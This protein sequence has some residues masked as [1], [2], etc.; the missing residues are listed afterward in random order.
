[1]V[2]AGAEKSPAGTRKRAMSGRRRW[3][4]WLL[5]VLALS[6]C[7]T[8]PLLYKRGPT[9]VYWWLDAYLDLDDAQQ[10]TARAA[11]ND[12][13][14]WHRESQLAH[15][16]SALAALRRDAA[17]P[18]TAARV[19]AANEDIRQY[20][21]AGLEHAV[22]AFATLAVSL[23]A[24]Q[25]RLLAERYRES[26]EELRDRQLEGTRAERHAR[27]TDE[28]IDV[29]RDL[30]GRLTREQK[31]LIEQ[32]VAASPYDPERGL[33]EREARQRDTLAALERIAAL[34]AGGRTKAAITILEALGASF[35]ASP[36]AAYR[37]YHAALTAYN[38]AFIADVHNGSSA[39]QRA[40][41]L[42]KLQGW[43]DDLRGLMRP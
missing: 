35:T 38:C 42:R 41:A 11:L 28:A 25:R 19:C 6:G 39:G 32:R 7:S 15:Y 5:L 16:A 14:R 40:K 31:A 30:Y 21:R 4:A 24:D 23:D 8:L 34:P 12:W 10:A 36:R 18:L 26:N 2:E 1:M 17:G 13:F 33:A 20:F 22:P 43:E 9:L 29:A 37:H 27:T 3:R